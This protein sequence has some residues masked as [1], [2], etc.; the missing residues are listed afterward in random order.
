M[1]LAGSFDNAED[2]VLGTQYFIDE[3]PSFY[4]FANETQDLTGAQVAEMMGLG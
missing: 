2:F 1:M 4:S 3:K